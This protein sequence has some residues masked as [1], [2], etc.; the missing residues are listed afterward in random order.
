M[1]WV[2]LPV[3]SN[4][5]LL[6]MV[7]RSGE[8]DDGEVFV[9]LGRGVDVIDARARPHWLVNEVHLELGGASKMGARSSAA[10]TSAHARSSS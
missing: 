1:G 7:A 4:S 6:L 5:S 3:M 2:T 9:C 8:K 10:L